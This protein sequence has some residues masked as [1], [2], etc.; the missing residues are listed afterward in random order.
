MRIKCTVMKP[1]YQ[2]LNPSRRFVSITLCVDLTMVNALYSYLVAQ[3]GIVLAEDL[4]RY[5]TNQ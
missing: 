3:G 5:A 2:S 4:E 1:A